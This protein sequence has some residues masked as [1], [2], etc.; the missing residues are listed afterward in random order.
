MILV[1]L[2]SFHEFL[3]FRSHGCFKRSALSPS[4]QRSTMP[5]SKSCTHIHRVGTIVMHKKSCWPVKYKK[6]FFFINIYNK[7]IFKLLSTWNCASGTFCEG[8]EG[9]SREINMEN[10]NKYSVSCI[11]STVI[12]QTFIF[13]FYASLKSF[14]R[15]L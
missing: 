14:T 8:A 1:Y 11:I 15:K 6:I 4:S 10:Y 13:N 3:Y 9:V 2:N 12:L 7:I 5:Y